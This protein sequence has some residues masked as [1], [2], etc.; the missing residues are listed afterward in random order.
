MN[1]ANSPK[2]FDI[3][4]F[5]LDDKNQQLSTFIDETIQNPQ[6]TGN[7]NIKIYESQT[8]CTFAKSIMLNN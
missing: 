3:Y 5:F 4:P 1:T 6:F 8:F 7:E 2:K